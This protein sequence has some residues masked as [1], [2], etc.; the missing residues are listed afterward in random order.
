MLKS[1]PVTPKLILHKQ[2][3]DHTVSVHWFYA[4][5]WSLIAIL[6][7]PNANGCLDVGAVDTCANAANSVRIE[8]QQLETL[9]WMAELTHQPKPFFARYKPSR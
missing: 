3:P 2:I 5:F 8:T 6:S 1:A 9:P 4:E 7:T